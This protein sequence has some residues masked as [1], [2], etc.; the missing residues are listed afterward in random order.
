[1]CG[2]KL[3]PFPSSCHSKHFYR[4]NVISTCSYCPSPQGVVLSGEVGFVK[5]EHCSGKSWHWRQRR[6]T[7][8]NWLES[9][10]SPW[11]L[12]LSEGSVEQCNQRWFSTASCPPQH[13]PY[14]WWLWAASDSLPLPR[15]ASGASPLLNGCCPAASSCWSS[16]HLGCIQ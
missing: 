16:E 6:K 7:D 2:E 3:N 1:M 12:A 10:G 5:S 8:W 15:L 13:C 14:T 11:G 9:R 4:S